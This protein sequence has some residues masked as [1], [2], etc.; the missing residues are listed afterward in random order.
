[1]LTA[2]SQFLYLAPEHREAL[3]GLVYS[4]TH[5]K[6]FALLTGDAGTGKTT[7]VRTV[8]KSVPAALCRF[9]LLINPTLT[10][11]EFLELV[12]LQFGL[13]DCPPSKA[14]Q[15]TVLHDFLLRRAEQGQITILIVDEAHKLSPELLE[16]IRLLTNFETD[17]GKLLQ[18]LLVAQNELDEVLEQPH[19]R[20][21]KQR[22]AFRF[23]LSPFPTE[24]I[25]AYLKFRWTQAG[26]NGN[27]PFSED[28][29]D[30]LGAFSGG[31]PR[32]INTISDN[33][34]LL[35]FA[36]DSREVRPEHIVIAAKDLAFRHA[37]QPV[38]AARPRV[39]APPQDW[40]PLENV[41]EMMAAG[42]GI[43]PPRSD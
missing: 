23:T 25:G 9:A 28:C 10:R 16:E 43:K 15:L 13:G 5:R 34:L 22:I 33:S 36:E 29:I 19:L 40:A 41:Q 27:M 4:I 14:R 21:L 20:Q 38:A 35:A 37:E 31:I 39:P 24:Q 32:L 17:R 11:A 7:V 1:M 8:L 12:L 6:G 42:W 26:G 3:S 30:Y 2:D 18:I